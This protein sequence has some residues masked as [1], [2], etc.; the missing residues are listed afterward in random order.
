MTRRRILGSRR[1]GR[2]V[3]IAAG[4]VVGA[5]VGVLT[6]LLTSTWNWWLFAALVFLISAASVLVVWTEGPR[7]EPALNVAVGVPPGPST[8][9]AGPAVSPA[10]SGLATDTALSAVFQLPPDA[11]HFI[12]RQD[13]LTQLLAALDP[14]R[15][16]RPA[17]IVVSAIA[18]KGGVG[19]TALAL[20][21]AHRL[22]A[23]Y[24]DG[25]LYVDLRGLEAQPLEPADVLAGFLRA[26]GVD[27]HAIS[28][29]LEDRLNL[30]RSRLAGRRVLIVLDNAAS[31][32]QVRP[33]LPGSSS[34]AVIVTSRRQ[35]VALESTESISVEVLDS[36]EALELLAKIIGTG[37]AAAE[38]EA[39]A[40]IV[41]YCGYLPLAVRVAGARLVARRHW[42]LA[43]MAALLGD[44]RRR[45]RELRAGDLE[46]RASFVVSYN[47]QDEIH[48]RAFRRLGL[49][50]VTDFPAWNAA[51]VLDVSPETGE[52]LLEDL[53][54]AQ[55]VEIAGRTRSDAT[56]Y[57][58]HDLLRDFARECAEAAE[59]PQATRSAIER[60]LG[61][62]LRLAERA[63]T[64]LEPGVRNVGEGSSLRWPG[65][66]STFVAAIVGDDPQGWF[67][68]ERANLVAAVE[69]AWEHQLYD[70]TW[71]LAGLFAASFAVRI[72][73][74]EWEHTHELALRATDASG[75]VRGEAFIRRSLGRLYR[76]QGRWDEAR[77]CYEQALDIFRSV[78]DPLWQG[79]TH[80]NLG[81]L[82]RDLG[83]L[84][85][86]VSACQRAL[87]IFDELGDRQWQAATLISLGETYLKLDQTEDAA[88]CYLRCLPIFEGG[89]QRWW[90]AVTLVALGDVYRKQGRDEEALSLLD[91]GLH[92]FQDLEDERRT[93]LT[94]FSIGQVH[95]A[96]GRWTEAV[97]CFEQCLTTFRRVSDRLWEARA[98]DALADVHRR[99]GATAQSRELWSEA[100]AIF[101]AVRA[102]EAAEVQAKLAELSA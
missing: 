14:H 11:A 50:Q 13:E 4:P 16:D 54:E 32:A 94:L 88:A 25:Q 53:C 34:C 47:G 83:E 20:R 2:N 91:D 87:Q 55:L 27:Q 46:V 81:D 3:L 60:V 40:Q 30:Y 93:S 21:A 63:D 71:E 72:Y 92:I 85:P 8:G 86:A 74:A 100:A 48:Q 6:N 77:A 66:G 76:Y 49:L 22:A 31:E 75:D 29:R 69:Q 10:T 79:V 44:E 17:A 102:P 24:P 12:G 19:K 39:A 64:L 45:L 78:E 73:P 96:G 36:D 28:D 18:G 56:R 52:E 26:L 62:Y 1:A 41:R 33:L 67:A 43:D 58:F 95:A 5:L 98:L 80:R 38:P 57:R 35:L 68:T 15:S 42:R 99:C 90:R 84:S 37:R 23:A 101:S 65:N 51:A 61:G 89:G 70:L 9:S 59:T 7:T 82:H 97:A